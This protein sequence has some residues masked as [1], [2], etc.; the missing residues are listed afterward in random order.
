V[1][2]D[3]KILQELAV[4]MDV[5]GYL[6]IMEAKHRATPTGMGYSATRF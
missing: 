2:F 6:R 4:R 3:H 1:S 5:T